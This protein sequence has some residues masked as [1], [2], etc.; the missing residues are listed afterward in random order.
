MILPQTQALVGLLLAMLPG[1]GCSSSATLTNHDS[2]SSPDRM[3]EIR[4][5]SRNHFGGRVLAP[6]WSYDGKSIVF[7]KRLAPEGCGQVFAVNVSHSSLG[8]PQLQSVGLVI[9]ERRILRPPGRRAFFLEVRDPSPR[10][11]RSRGFQKSRR[12][13]SHLRRVSGCQTA[14]CCIMQMA[15]LYPRRFNWNQEH[16]ALFTPKS[17]PA[18]TGA[19]FLRAID[20]AIPIFTVQSL[21]RWAR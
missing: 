18:V 4:P 15:P 21:I 3:S 13:E 19:W 2:Q 5:I 14:F 7:L 16:P 17:P 8:T 12:Q 11:V 6:R 20:R 9:P 10:R 1:L